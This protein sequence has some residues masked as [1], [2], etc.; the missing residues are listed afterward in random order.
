MSLKWGCTWCLTKCT[1]TVCQACTKQMQ[2][3]PVLRVRTGHGWLTEE[4][5]YWSEGCSFL[6]VGPRCHAKKTFEE[7]NSGVKTTLPPVFPVP[8]AQPQPQQQLEDDMVKD[9]Q[10]FWSRRLAMDGW[11]E[12]IYTFL[13]LLFPKR[14]KAG[15]PGCGRSLLGVS[16]RRICRIVPSAPEVTFCLVVGTE[17]SWPQNPLCCYNPGPSGVWTEEDSNRS[18]HPAMFREIPVQLLRVGQFCWGCWVPM[19]P[20]GLEATSVWGAYWLL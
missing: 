7:P 17:L 6:S 13:V 3:A 9:L 10:S 14:G 12:D 15:V 2:A 19:M 11:I 16:S 20:S 4:Q 8:P 5:C 1:W 18:G